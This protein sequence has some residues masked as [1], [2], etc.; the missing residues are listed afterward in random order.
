MAKRTYESDAIRVFWDSSRC[1]HA[2][3]CVR[4][5]E[6]TFDTQRR[7]WVDLTAA[8]AEVVASTIEQCPSGALQFERLDGSPGEQVQV[9][10]TI[11]PLPNGPNAVRGNFDVTDRHGRSFSVGPRATLCRCGASEN[12]PFC[13]NAHR[14]AG[15]RSYP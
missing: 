6:G 13:D 2:G 10:T 12:Q 5:G 8:E 7:P 1:I 4:N 15:F 14:E 11:I 3:F 9:P